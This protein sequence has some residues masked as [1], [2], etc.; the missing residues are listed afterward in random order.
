[1]TDLTRYVGGFG[2]SPCGHTRAGGDTSLIE[3][4]FL[5]SR[6][7][8]KQR[9]VPVTQVLR[10]FVYCYSSFM[11]IADSRVRIS[12]DG[13]LTFVPVFGSGGFGAPYNGTHSK[14]LR[15]DGHTIAVY[16]HKTADW[17]LASKIVIEFVGVDE[18]GNVAT[19]IAPVWW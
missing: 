15:Y 12:E 6:P 4:R 7:V 10:F 2:I 1:M 5:S 18:Y 13:G 9:N 11:E 14:V 17:P 3:P 16:I 8:D 19:R